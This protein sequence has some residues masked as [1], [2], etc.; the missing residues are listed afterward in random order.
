MSEKGDGGLER[1]EAGL[2]KSQGN[3]GLFPQYGF[4]E[5]Y[6]LCS[7]R[8][9]YFNNFTAN[10]TANFPPACF[11]PPTCSPPVI[12][13]GRAYSAELLPLHLLPFARGCPLARIIIV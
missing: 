6:D 2:D 13:R 5:R 12:L 7:L 10:F 4:T 8:L 11:D 9:P 3:R 1:G